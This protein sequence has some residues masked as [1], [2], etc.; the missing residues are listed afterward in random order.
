MAMH[1]LGTNALKH[2]ALSNE[3]GRVSVRWHVYRAETGSRLKLVWREEDGPPVAEPN[4]LGF[5]SRLIERGLAAELR[6][7]VN[8]QFATTGLVCTV[9][10]P[11]PGPVGL[12]I[13]DQAVE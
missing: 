13:G 11:L 6:G 2:G 5:G 4:K 1:E 12:S 3:S 9:D 8:L 7:T 10:A